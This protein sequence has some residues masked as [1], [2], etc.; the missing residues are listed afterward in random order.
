MSRLYSS[1]A[2]ALEAVK[3]IQVVDPSAMDNIVNVDTVATVAGPFVQYSAPI[4]SEVSVSGM[5]AETLLPNMD[6]EIREF[7]KH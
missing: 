2:E 5:K 4:E 3:N 1:S 7:L 6:L